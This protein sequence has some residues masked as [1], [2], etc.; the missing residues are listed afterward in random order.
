MSPDI[1]D[2]A[3][4]SRMMA[5]IRSS[6]TS[7]ERE[8]RSFLHRMGLR[9]GRNRGLPGSPDIVMPGRGI[10][11]FVHGCFWHRHANCKFAYLPKSNIDAWSRKFAQNM[12]RDKRVA[13]SLRML[14]WRVLTIWG[15]QLDDRHLQALYRK[16]DLS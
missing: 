4:R 13:R 16:I 2:A 9:F 3:T 6:G 12:K 14:G 1:V 5:G 7:P 8:V 10:V 15:C 11:V